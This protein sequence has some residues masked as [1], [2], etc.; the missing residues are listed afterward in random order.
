MVKSLLA[1]KFVL[2]IIVFRADSVAT[3]IP[4]ILQGW[5]FYVA[6]LREYVT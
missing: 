4:K 3:F 1:S 5:A 6:N 2:A